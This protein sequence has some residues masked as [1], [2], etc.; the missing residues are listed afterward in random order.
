MVREVNDVKKVLSDEETVVYDFNRRLPFWGYYPTRYKILDRFINFQNEL[1]GYLANI[2]SGDI[3]SG[4]EDILD[5]LI[6]DIS[7][8]AAKSLSNQRTD[9]RDVI[10]S[11][12]IRTHSDREAFCQQLEMLKAAL[13]GNKKKQAIYQSLSNNEEF[14]GGLIHEK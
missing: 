12:D 11:F 4:N 14:G 9:H 6:I 3:D 5:N 1:D 7:M 8:Q 10:K 13:D 2:F